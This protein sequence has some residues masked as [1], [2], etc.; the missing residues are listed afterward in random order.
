M[1]TQAGKPICLSDHTREYLVR[2]GFT[3]TEVHEATRTSP[4]QPAQRGRQE[5]IKDFPLTAALQRLAESIRDFSTRE[6]A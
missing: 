4:W 5:V 2:R 3:E 1:N 6:A